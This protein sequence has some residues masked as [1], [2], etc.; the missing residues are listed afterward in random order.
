[1]SLPR[2]LVAEFSLLRPVFKSGQSIWV[3][4]DKVAPKQVF[5]KHFGFLMPLI[6]L[7]MLIF[8]SIIHNYYNMPNCGPDT[9]EIKSPSNPKIIKT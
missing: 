6:I 9:M 2:L 5:S 1:M 8:S 7:T 4:V 3:A